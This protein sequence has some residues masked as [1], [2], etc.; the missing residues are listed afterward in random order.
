MFLNFNLKKETKNVFTSM[1]EG[2]IQLISTAFL[3][4]R[5]LGVTIDGRLTTSS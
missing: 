1:T 5:E 2:H 4:V 3:T